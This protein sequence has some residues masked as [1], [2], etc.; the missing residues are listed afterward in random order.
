MA[1]MLAGRVPAPSS[2]SDNGKLA[3][4]ANTARRHILALVALA[5]AV[6]AALA[7]QPTPPVRRVSSPGACT[8]RWRR[9]GSTR[10]RRRA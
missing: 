10:R 5:L 9:R 2:I 8:S 3:R 1:T 7:R 4:G 6:F